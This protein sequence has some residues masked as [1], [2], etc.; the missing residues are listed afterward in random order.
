MKIGGRAVPD[1]IQLKHWL[2]L[3]PDTKAAQRVLISDIADLAGNIEKEAE[4]LLLKLSDAGIRHPILKV[5][6][7][8]IATRAA[9]LLRIIDRA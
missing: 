4:A 1:T 9:H 6:R 7:G 5:V 3:V 8:V 2:S